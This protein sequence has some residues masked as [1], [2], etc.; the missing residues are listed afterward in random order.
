MVYFKIFSI[1]L[2]IFMVL[3]YP[4]LRF[5]AKS[6][7]DLENKVYTEEQPKW[8]YFV[9]ILGIALAI[10]TWYM[11]FATGVRFS[12][13]V[14]LIYTGSLVKS[15]ILMFAYSLFQKWAE[16]LINQDRD[17]LLQM[18]LKIMVVGIILILLGIFVY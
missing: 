12:W 4:W 8:V 11:V 2:G 16:K 9:G 14:A 18:H 10:F 6:S 15:L 1:V 5:S 7:Q 3:K 13:I 17:A